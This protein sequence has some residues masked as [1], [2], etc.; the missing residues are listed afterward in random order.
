[1]WPGA[2]EPPPAP[3]KAPHSTL[4]YFLPQG[5]N[6]LPG[7]QNRG[8]R[9]WSVTKSSGILL[10]ILL[11]SGV[12]LQ[13][14]NNQI[15]GGGEFSVSNVCCFPWY[16]SSHY[17]QFHATNRKSLN[18]EMGRDVCKRVQAGSSTPRHTIPPSWP[19]LHCS[20]SELQ[21]IQGPRICPC[22]RVQPHGPLFLESFPGTF[23][24]LLSHFQ[25][26]QYPVYTELSHGAP[27]VCFYV[28]LSHWFMNFLST[29]TDGYDKG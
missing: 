16:T 28:S 12:C 14:F 27:M 22:W 11:P 8:E 23:L 2:E 13:M 4:S 1:M 6:L 20:R 9:I 24:L 19:C 25:D 17:C 15:F 5:T 3:S 7:H 18:T 29:E 26:L 10:Q 21:G